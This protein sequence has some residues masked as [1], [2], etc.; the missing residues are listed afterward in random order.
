VRLAASLSLEEMAALDVCLNWDN[1]I[2]FGQL[3][4]PP[5]RTANKS[6]KKLGFSAR[7]PVGGPFL[8][9]L[10]IQAQNRSY[11]WSKDWRWSNGRIV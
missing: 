10:S 3:T 11:S 7:T 2:S 6:G 1:R 9:S 4:A 5:K 8:S